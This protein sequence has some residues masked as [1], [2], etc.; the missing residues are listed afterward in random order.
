MEQEDKLSLCSSNEQ[1]AER[2]LNESDPDEISNIIDIFNLNIK[3]KDIIRAGKMSSLQ[4]AIFNQMQV[5]IEKH[6]DEFSNKDLADYYRLAKDTLDKASLISV[7]DSIP[8]VQ[9]QQ[10]NLNIKVDGVQYSR[11]SKEKIVDTVSVLLEK[12]RQQP[13][14]VVDVEDYTESEEEN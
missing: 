12:L 4:D 8:T 11:E 7:E 5:R 3:K 1:L 10:N 14:Q 6:A 9:I 13:Q 2:I